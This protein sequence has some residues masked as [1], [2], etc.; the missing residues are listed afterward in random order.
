VKVREIREHYDH[1][2]VFYRMF[3]GL[4]IHH[5]YWEDDEPPAVAQVQLTER[6][7]EFAAV[8]HGARLLDVGC[9]LGGSAF[10]LARHRNCLITAITLSPIQV[11]MATRQ[12]RAEGLGERVRFRRHDANQ[13][14]LPQSFDVIWIVECS[15]HLEDK[16]GF[17]GSCARLLDPGG[18]IA[19]CAWVASGDPECTEH[20]RLVKAVCRGML[21]PSLARAEAYVN[22][23]RAS[24]LEAVRT[25]DI[26]SRVSRTWT[27]CERIA[28]RPI[29]RLG[30]LLL[31]RRT[32]DF[33]QSF[34]M[35]QRAYEVG[36]MAYWMFTARK[37]AEPYNAVSR[38]A[39][40]D[41]TRQEV[42]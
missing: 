3:W 1:L 18:R 25:E 2:S 34:G 14:A 22:W 36:A 10:W 8:P 35:I 28:S 24:G 12:A 40:L 4:H 37:P 15:E 17:I 21:C 11:W 38:I 26:T 19:L 41:S 39:H 33:V 29:V 20:S 31:G 32:R 7:A 5:G 13:L 42:R 6:L 30:Q 27:F 16:R 9:G 23:L